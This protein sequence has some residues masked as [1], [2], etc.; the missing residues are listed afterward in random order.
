MR[1]SGALAGDLVAVQGIGGLGYLALQCAR[2]M[3]F[4]V[5]AVGRGADIS[6]K[7]RALGAHCYIDT[8]DEDPVQALQAMGGAQIILTTITDSAAASALAPTGKFLVVGVCKTPL[9]LAP[10]FLVSGERVVEGSITGTPLESE[11]TLD[12]SVLTDIR[13]GIDTMPLEHV[14][15]AYERMLSGKAQFHMVLTMNQ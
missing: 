15:E 4:R 14:S 7:V 10:G 13:P 11:R 3:G 2:K 1:K 5:V 12:F 8:N 6:E 9:T